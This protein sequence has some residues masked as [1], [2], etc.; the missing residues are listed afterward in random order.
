[1]NSKAE[2]VNVGLYDRVN[3]KIPFCG[4]SFSYSAEWPKPMV[5]IVLPFV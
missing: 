5:V 4:W 3:S 2:V 1:M